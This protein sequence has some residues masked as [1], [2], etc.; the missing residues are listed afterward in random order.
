MWFWLPAPKAADEATGGVT[1]YGQENDTAT[2]A[3]SV[4]N[5]WLHGKITSEIKQGNTIATPL[6]TDERTGYLKTF[7]YVVANPPFSY[8]SWSNGI[9]PQHDVYERFTGFGIPPSKN[10]DYA[11][12]L[13]I[14][15]SLKSKG[16]GACILPHGVLFRG[17]TEGEIRTNIIKRGYIKGIIGLPANL[18]YGTGIPACIIVIDKE[19]SETRKG[20]FMIDASKGFIKDGNKNRLREQDIHKI[21]DVFNRQLEVTKYSRMVPLEEIEKNEYNLNIPRYIDSQE[22]E[23]IQDIEAH[24][25]GDIPVRD[26][27]DL[28]EFWEVYPT[29]KN[30]LFSENNRPG[31]LKLKIEKDKIKPTIFNHPEFTI[32]GKEMETTFEKWEKDTVSYLKQLEKELRP[33]EVISRIS[34]NILNSYQ[35]LRLIDR[36]DVYQHLMNY[37]SEI[38]QD[39]L[40]EIAADGWESG[41]EVL[42]LTKEDKKGKKRDVEGM[43]GLAG[44][45]IPIELMIEVYFSKEKADIDELEAEKETVIA[46]M[47]ELREEHGGEEGLLSEVMDEKGKISKKTLT[48][49]LK[50]I[51]KKS[52]D[53]KEELSLLKEYSKLLDEEAELKDKIKTAWKKLEVKVIKKYPVLTVDE[54][55]KTVTEDKWMKSIEKAVHSETDRISQR[56]TG[57]IKE[58]AER[59]ETPLPELKKTV[60]ELEQKVNS[61]LGRMGFTW[62]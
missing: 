40:Y 17:N 46:K 51:G 52:S 9:N 14:I 54:V 44:R 24:L 59:Y 62:K 16:K 30:D 4:M 19:N 45:L 21:V 6:F 41:K 39:D 25:L 55:K 10:G 1:I 18:F 26:I 22:A 61:H 56:L 8:K 13:H 3:L 57:R 38:M 36:Y 29:L 23:D 34:E 49:H 2:R 31:Y 58:L 7:D 33:K 37:W 12:L 60:E 42:R 27:E 47:D 28:K 48:A 35:N 15:K 32:Y 5:M 43:A 11:F 53:N 50:E 20:I